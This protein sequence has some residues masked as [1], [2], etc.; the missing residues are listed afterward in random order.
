[1]NNSCSPSL[2]TPDTI[3]SIA[4]LIVSVVVGVIVWVLKTYFGRK[5]D[6]VHTSVRNLTPAS[7]PLTRSVD[8]TT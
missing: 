8:Q 7:T 5:I 2:F 6:D 3:I 1:M 4:T